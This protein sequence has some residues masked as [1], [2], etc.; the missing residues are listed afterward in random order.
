MLEEASADPSSPRDPAAQPTTGSG[1]SS[2]PPRRGKSV[3]SPRWQVCPA[4]RAANRPPPPTRRLSCSPLPPFT[5]AD[6]LNAPRSIKEARG[7]T[8]AD[9]WRRVHDAELR[10]HDT[11]LLTCTYED[12]LPTVKPLQFTIRYRAKTNMYGGLECR[13]ARCAIRGDRMRPGVDFDEMRTTSQVLSEP[14]MFI[15]EVGP[16]QYARMEADND[17]FS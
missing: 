17:D 6:L 1:S 13:K 16:G 10:R 7:R 12:P 14:S 9:E 5:T 11:E 3:S 4:P 2:P 15:Q 8:D